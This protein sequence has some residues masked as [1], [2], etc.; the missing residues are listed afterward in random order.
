MDWPQKSI[1]SGISGVII[2][3]GTTGFSRLIVAESSEQTDMQAKK[4]NRHTASTDI[5]F[6][7]IFIE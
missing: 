4:N 7:F 5:I 1:W 6:V 2:M 3:D